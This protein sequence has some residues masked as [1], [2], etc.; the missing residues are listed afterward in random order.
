[1]FSKTQPAYAGV[2]GAP[3]FVAAFR[4]LCWPQSITLESA[5]F[6]LGSNLLRCRGNTLN[7]KRKNISRFISY[8]VVNHGHKT[9]NWGNTHTVP[10]PIERM[11]FLSAIRP[12]HT[13]TVDSACM[14]CKPNWSTVSYG[15]SF[16]LIFKPFYGVIFIF[17]SPLWNVARVCVIWTIVELAYR[18]CC[19][20]MQGGFIIK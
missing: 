3:C 11:N 19:S 17:C 6:L 12:L 2:G 9:W 5:E 1:M 16:K 4:V 14:Q 20:I 18:V 7:R 8:F 13:Y 10:T 15:G